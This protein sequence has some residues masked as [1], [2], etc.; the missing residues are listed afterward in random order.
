VDFTKD[1]LRQFHARSSA[2]G[3]GLVAADFAGYAIA[4]AAAL[5][6]HGWLPQLLFAFIASIFVGRLFMLGHDACHQSLTPNRRLNRWLGTIAFLPSLHPFSLWDLGHNRIHHRFTNQRDRDYVWEPLDPAEYVALS[7][8]GRWHYRLYRSPLGHLC[9]YPAQIWW[10]KMFFPRPSEIGGYEREYVWDHLIV[11]A[12]MLGLV[13]LMLAVRAPWHAAAPWQDGVATLLIAGVMPMAIFQFSM[14]AV[15]YLHHTHRRVTWARGP[16][17]SPDQLGG[18]VHVVLP[19]FLARTLHHIMDHTAHHARP[20]IPLYHLSAG[21]AVLEDRHESVI[22]ERWTPAFHLE[23]L[24]TCKLF[25]L[26]RREWVPF[27]RRGR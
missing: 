11:L 13:A 18:S 26:Q 14:S 8:V 27:P 9:Y 7:A 20:G 2:L 16:L 25:D 6:E 1:E 21:Q 3:V 19:G 12:W 23:T 15:I 17:T 24:R 5:L 22:V 10:R 4:V